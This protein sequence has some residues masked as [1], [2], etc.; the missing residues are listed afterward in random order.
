MEKTCKNIFKDWISE[1]GD[2]DVDNKIEIRIIKG[3]NQNHPYW[4]RVAIGQSNFS[5]L[6]RSEQQIYTV[7]IK[8]HTM[9]PNNDTN[10]KMFERELKIANKFM[11]CPSYF[12]N[13]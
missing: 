8:L 2:N 3:I 5:S 4:Y 6:P 9:Q 1:V 10:I 13:K 11:I 12:Q 7:P